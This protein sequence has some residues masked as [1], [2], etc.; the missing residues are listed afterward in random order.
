MAALPPAGGGCVMEDGE[1][2]QVPLG[3]IWKSRNLRFPALAFP[4]ARQ[5]GKGDSVWTEE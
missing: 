1:G 5:A 4:E 3:G 2:L